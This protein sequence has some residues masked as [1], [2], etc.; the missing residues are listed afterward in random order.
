MLVFAAVIL[1]FVAFARPARA[2]VDSPQGA[3]DVAGIVPGKYA[4]MDRTKTPIGPAEAT[5]SSVKAIVGLMKQA[6]DVAAIL[7][8]DMPAAPAVQPSVFVPMT[9]VDIALKVAAMTPKFDAERQNARVSKLLESRG[10]L[11]PV[12][13]FIFSAFNATRG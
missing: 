6:I 11:W 1:A 9:D 13:G 7:P 10:L 2:N 12:E 8:Q 3:L 4:F 5:V